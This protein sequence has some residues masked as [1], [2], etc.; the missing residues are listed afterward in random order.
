ME[1]R[2]PAAGQFG[3]LLSIRKAVPSSRLKE[4]VTVPLRLCSVA[5]RGE[6]TAGRHTFADRLGNYTQSCRF[7]TWSATVK[8]SLGSRVGNEN[9][10]LEKVKHPLG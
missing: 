9:G 7:G 6:G 4:L 10:D 5:R 3:I 2:S 8:M 1:G